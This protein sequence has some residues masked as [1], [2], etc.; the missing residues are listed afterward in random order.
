MPLIGVTTFRDCSDKGGLRRA[1][2]NESY[3]KAVVEA[4]GIPVLIPI[5]LRQTD[6]PDLCS[7][8]DGILL[9]GGEDINPDVYHGIPH[10]S[11]SASD[12]DRDMLE[13]SLVKSALDNKI[14]FL[15]IC[16][17]CQVMNVALG[18]TLFSDIQTQKTDS[19]RHNY[20]PPHQRDQLS[21]KVSV[22]SDSLLKS[23]T[24]RVELQVNSL[25]HQ[26]IDKVAASLKASANC[27]DDG[28]VEALEYSD[29]PFALGVQW[30]P[31]ELQAHPE[32]RAI[33]QSLVI[34]SNARERPSRTG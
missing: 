17:G 14:P 5:G 3:I 29:H 12:D 8:L 9:T 6:L 24:G 28:L 30:H 25:H 13:I 16:R 18:G 31:E 19:R 15:G 23:I 4:G 21:H 26:G 11:V 27:S 2:V 10:T 34:A 22:A 33:F 7:R 1:K 20:F 32:M